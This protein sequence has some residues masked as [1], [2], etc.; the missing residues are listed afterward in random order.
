MRARDIDVDA[1]RYQP[2]ASIA[3]RTE[4]AQLG[5]AP[6][7]TPPRRFLQQPMDVSQS[8]RM[9]TQ[10]HAVQAMSG[11]TLQLDA[12]EDSAPRQGRS[13]GAALQQSGV[14][15]PLQLK[16]I[17]NGG[18]YL[19]WDAFVGT[20]RWYFNKET[21]NMF[22]RQ[23]GLGELRN[24]T[25]SEERTREEWLADLNGEDPL[26][27]EDG[28]VVG[29]SNYIEA[30]EKGNQENR[31]KK[32]LVSA[33]DNWTAEANAALFEIGNKWIEF[34]GDPLKE[35]AAH[36]CSGEQWNTLD[37]GADVS[38]DMFQPGYRDPESSAG[39]RQRT[40]LAHYEGEAAPIAVMMLEVRRHESVQENNDYMYIRW[41]VAHPTR[42]GG[43]AALIAE[44][45]GSAA[46]TTSEALRVESARSAI[47]WYEK[48]GLILFKRAAHET[49]E[50]CGC[51]EM[52]V[53]EKF[54]D[55][56]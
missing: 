31:H 26:A 43:A 7:R 51:G 56:D 30:R 11:A 20:A 34:G 38:H 37:E 13:E 46:L 3:G 15:P 22:Y 2:A 17:D 18:K 48:Q 42:G 10:R 49:E 50:L 28:S 5:A 39:G 47:R 12:L 36:E 45:I 55:S 6:D 8:P 4:G 16:W 27:R 25:E 35:K 29:A 52:G 9:L 44:A 41:L 1:A 19:V 53:G 54:K 23:A 14:A 32:I 40:Y 21:N 24:E 33:S